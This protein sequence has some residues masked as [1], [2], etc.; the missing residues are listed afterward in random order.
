MCCFGE[1]ES[2]HSKMLTQVKEFAKGHN[3]AHRGAGEQDLNLDLQDVGLSC[4]SLVPS[5]SSP[6]SDG[7]FL[8]KFKTCLLELVRP[9]ADSEVFT[10][11]PGYVGP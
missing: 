7:G 11:D 3:A 10:V 1:F 2:H 4:R 8:L 6:I 5:S 9:L